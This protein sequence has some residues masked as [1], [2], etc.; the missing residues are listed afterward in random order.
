MD[1]EVNCEW[2]LKSNT[3]TMVDGI[4]TVQSWFYDCCTRKLLTIAQTNLSA[5]P[6]IS[7]ILHIPGYLLLGATAF[8][9]DPKVLRNI[10]PLLCKLFM[11]LWAW[12]I[13]NTNEKMNSSTE[14][15]S[16]LGMDVQEPTGSL[17]YSEKKC[18]SEIFLDIIG[19]WSTSVTLT[20]DFMPPLGYLKLWSSY[21]VYTAS[22]HIRCLESVH[23][24][25]NKSIKGNSSVNWKLMPVQRSKIIGIGK[26]AN[27]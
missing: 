12:S 20:V 23:W 22:W 14:A 8:P 4:H 3:L 16:W 25:Y 11:L 1:I 10:A 7:S 6:W 9:V 15:L 5:V 13:R 17:R 21:T 19:L 26:E 2:H 18:M 27:P 24:V